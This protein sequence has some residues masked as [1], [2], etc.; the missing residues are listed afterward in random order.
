MRRDAD[1]RIAGLGLGIGALFVAAG[2]LTALSGALS[3]GATWLP[4]HLV[5]AGGAGTAIAGMLPFFSAALAVAPPADPRLRL[6]AV[7]TVAV[8]ALLVV[9]SV[10]IGDPFLGHVGGTVYLVGIVLAGIAGYRPLRRALGPRRRLIERAY[11]AAFAA[12]LVGVLL[13]TAMLAG[14]A[15]VVRRWAMLKP[16]HVWLNLIGS[17][18]VIIVATLTHLGPTIEGTRMQPRA[19]ARVALVGLTVGPAMVALA[20]TLRLD[21]LARIGAAIAL[22]GATGVVVHTLAVRSSDEPWTTDVHWHRFATWSLRLGSAW[23]LAGMVVL[24]GRVVWLGADPAAMSLTAIGIPVVVGWVLQVL[25]GSWSHLIPALGPGEPATRAR[26]RELL[27]H[28]AMARL[29][30][31]NAGILAAWLGLWLEAPALLLGGSL[32]VGLALG[33]SVG[34][35]AAAAHGRAAPLP[36]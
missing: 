24:A 29:T 18:S 11:L 31:L 20:Y 26:R 32:A 25:V 16:A 7:G 1:R 19:T 2:L 33:A 35:A 3:G 34:L 22:V 28:G 4:L 6:A 21:P 14:W 12:A 17:L 15:P 9:G 23:F 13:V 8:G 27:S 5:L 10:S 30:V 36:T